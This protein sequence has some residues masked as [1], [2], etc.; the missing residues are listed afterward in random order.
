MN[1][2]RCG[3]KSPPLFDTVVLASRRTT[4]CTGAA[5]S[6]LMIFF[7]TLG[8]ARGCKSVMLLTYLNYK[9][10]FQPELNS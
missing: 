6:T 9:A 7:H 8:A 5:H 3:H 1:G 4:A 10:S 2:S